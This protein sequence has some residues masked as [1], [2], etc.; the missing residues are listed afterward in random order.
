MDYT[1]LTIM[2]FMFESVRPDYFEYLP[3]EAAAAADLYVGMPLAWDEGKLKAA[4]GTPQ[5]I[6]MADM[7]GVTAEERLPVMRLKSSTV[8]ELTMEGVEDA[9]PEEL[10]GTV[11]AEGFT[12]KSAEFDSV[13]EVLTVV[14][15]F[16][17]NYTA[18][19]A[20]GEV[21]GGT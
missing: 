5:Y 13:N 4:D 6:C 8:Y 11:V 21:P 20:G 17:P 19:E 12:A 9:T 14:A 2:P 15:N 10:L 18:A 7:T 3:F 16:D 1:K